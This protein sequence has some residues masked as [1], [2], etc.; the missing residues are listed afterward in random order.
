MSE[1]DRAAK[2]ARAKALLKKRQQK[3][4]A[5]TTTLNSGVASPIAPSRTFSPAPSE[6]VDEE[7][8]DLADVQFH[9]E[10]FRYIMVVFVAAR[11]FTSATRRFPPSPCQITAAGSSTTADNVTISQ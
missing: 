7:K 1:D 9:E 11:A 5:D 10:R 4:A 8:Q 6:P 3:K 2:A